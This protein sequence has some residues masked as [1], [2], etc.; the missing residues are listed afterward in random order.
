LNIETTDNGTNICTENQPILENRMKNSS[1]TPQS[2]NTFIKTIFTDAAIN[3][4][5]IAGIMIGFIILTVPAIVKSTDFSRAIEK[6]NKV[7]FLTG[8]TIL[9]CCLLIFS[10]RLGLI[11]NN[12]SFSGQ[13]NPMAPKIVITDCNGK[14]TKHF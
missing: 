7:I 4:I 5:L 10:R 2:S 3:N 6:H 1:I 8:S 11:C 9:I 12:K 14:S 13:T